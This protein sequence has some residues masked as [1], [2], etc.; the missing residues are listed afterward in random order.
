MLECRVH[1][2]GKLLW[3]RSD[4]FSKGLCVGSLFLIVEGSLVHGADREVI[5]LLG[6]PHSQRDKYCLVEVG[7]IHQRIGFLK[8]GRLCN[9]HNHLHMVISLSAFYRPIVLVFWTQHNHPLISVYR[10]LELLYLTVPNSSILLPK[11]SSKGLWTTRPSLSQ[12]APLV[13]APVVCISYWQLLVLIVNLTGSR[14][15]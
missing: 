7:Q 4:L 15:T 13:S 6:A 11:T 5:R 14:I 1:D 12:S 3:Y 2:T 9:G 8:V 10:T